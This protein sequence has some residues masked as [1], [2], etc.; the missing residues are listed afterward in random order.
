MWVADNTQTLHSSSNIV[1]LSPPVYKSIL[2]TA[3]YVKCELL[4]DQVTA[5][6][7]TRIKFFSRRTMGGKYNQN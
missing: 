6:A 2:A 7:A 5:Y 4:S 1:G 3:T